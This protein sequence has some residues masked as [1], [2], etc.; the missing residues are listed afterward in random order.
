MD[1]LSGTENIS[2]SYST[3]RT[4]L[5]AGNMERITVSGEEIT[6]Q[7]EAARVTELQAGEPTTY[8][9]FIT[10][11]PSFGDDAPLSLLETHDVEVMVTIRKRRSFS[12]LDWCCQQ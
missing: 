3:F 11:L 1:L 2:I 6:G 4:E 8:T 7:L 10:Y 12:L 5:V 9:H